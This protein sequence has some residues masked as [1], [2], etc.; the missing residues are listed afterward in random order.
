MSAL[1]KIPQPDFY[2]ARCGDRRPAV[3]NCSRKLKAIH[4]TRHLNV[5]KDD[6]DI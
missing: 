3:S 6:G 5:G 1:W 2:I 4:G